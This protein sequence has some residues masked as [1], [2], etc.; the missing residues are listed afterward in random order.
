MNKTTC[1]PSKNVFN[2]ILQSITTE[3]NLNKLINTKISD[4]V[5]S[6]KEEDSEKTNKNDNNIYDCKKWNTKVFIIDKKYVCVTCVKEKQ[7]QKEK[8][9]GFKG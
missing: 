9:E 8:E 5:N 7:I 2:D 6:H 4:E 1:L 3:K